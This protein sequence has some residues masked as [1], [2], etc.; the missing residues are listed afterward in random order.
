MNNNIVMSHNCSVDEE[1]TVGYEHDSDAAPTKLGTNGTVRAGTI[2]YCDV[3]IGD[4][5]TTGHNA[6]IREET[7]IGDDVLVG[8]NSVIDGYSKI[9]SYVSIQ[10]GVYVPSHT[11]IEDNVFL[12][13][14]C[15]LTNDPYPVRQET[16]LEGPT[17]KQGASIGANATILPNVTV[18]ENAFVAAGAV[19][20]DDVPPD[21]L[22]AGVPAEHHELPAELQGGNTLA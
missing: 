1:A 10:T 9:G 4:E 8:T 5:F 20:I 16:E 18:G 17:I 21:T 13:P 7:T 15:V 3:T 14:C 22:A 11:T 6:L 2:I 12:G 19:V